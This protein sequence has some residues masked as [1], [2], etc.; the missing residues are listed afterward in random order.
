MCLTLWGNEYLISLDGAP[1]GRLTVGR[2]GMESGLIKLFYLFRMGR[3]AYQFT[4]EEWITIGLVVGTL[5]LIYLLYPSKKST[6][7]LSKGEMADRVRLGIQRYVAE[8]PRFDFFETKAELLKRLKISEKKAEAIA[9]DYLAWHSYPEVSRPRL[10]H[11]LG[12]PLQTGY[13][14]DGEW[15]PGDR[16][17]L[18][19]IYISERGLWS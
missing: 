14:A 7:G 5:I 10:L 13:E 17:H 8:Q 11:F 16:E 18:A 15:Q 4:R 19:Q 6:R 3:W 2:H 9:E 1:S 12:V